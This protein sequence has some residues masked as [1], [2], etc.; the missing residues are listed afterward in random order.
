[1]AIAFGI[2]SK[3]K[4]ALGCYIALA[5]WES[6][7]DGYVLKDFKSAKVD[8]KKIKENTFYKLVNGKFVEAEE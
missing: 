2:D 6:T 7:D 4:G 1:M 8:G 3:A 5:E